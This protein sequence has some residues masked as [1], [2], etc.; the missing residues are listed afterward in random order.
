MKRRNLF[1]GT[2]HT[3]LI[4]TGYV[5]NN[6]PPKDTYESLAARSGYSV[7][8]AMAKISAIKP[9][10]TSTLGGTFFPW[11]GEGLSKHI[12]DFN[13]QFET[14]TISTSNT[15]AYIDGE[16]INDFSDGRATAEFSIETPSFLVGKTITIQDETSANHVF[17]PQTTD[18]YETGTL[19]VVDAIPNN[20]YGV[21][22]DGT[23]NVLLWYTDTL[24]T[25]DGSTINGTA[26]V[27][28]ILDFGSS[29]GSNGT[30][31]NDVFQFIAPTEIG[32][33][34][35]V[36]YIKLVGSLSGSTASHTCEVVRPTSD[37]STADRVRAAING[38]GDAAYD[39]AKISYGSSFTGG[40][41]GVQGIT[42]VDGTS[43]ELITV[44]SALP[45]SML[46]NGI[47]MKNKVGS[48]V[49][50]GSSYVWFT[51][52]LENAVVIGLS[53]VSTNNGRAGRIRTALGNI[54]SYSNG[55]TLNLT[56]SGATN[57]IILTR[58]DLGLGASYHDDIVDADMTFTN[59]SSGHEY[60]YSTDANIL[61]RN[62]ASAINRN[63]KFRSHSYKNNVIITMEASG[64]GGNDKT[65]TTNAVGGLTLSNSGKFSGGATADT[66]TFRELEG[67]DAGDLNGNSYSIL[68]VNSPGKF[69]KFAF[70]S[71]SKT[72]TLN[73]GYIYKGS[74]ATRILEGS[75]L[76][77]FNMVKLLNEKVDR[78]ID[79]NDVSLSDDGTIE[80][81][82]IKSTGAGDGK[83]LTANGSNGATWAPASGGG[84]SRWH[85]TMGGYKTNN[86]SSTN[87]YFQTYPNYHSWTSAD[88]SPT[89]I[90]YSYHDSSAFTAPAAAIIT[91]IDVSINCSDSGATDPLKF[92]I[93]KGTK[94][95]S[96]SSISLT[97]VGDSGT[98]TPVM[99]K[100]MTASATFSSGNALNAGD[101]VYVFIKKDSTTGN[102][103]QYFN[104]TISGEYT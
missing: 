91:R 63:S 37:D 55:I 68:E 49:T 86:N 53:G 51:G 79:W 65:V 81:T 71:S 12:D 74:L 78:I 67:T 58:T 13:S 28:D 17:E 39:A 85:V 10:Q 72:I 3:S 94:T 23:T 100:C 102:Q 26:Q 73:R 33:A 76:K 80:G 90:S 82:V 98:I 31:D 69:I 22:N 62:I 93:F 20:S 21:L 64:T 7:R 34:G 5:A 52:G 36:Q 19:T 8:D 50:G 48:I 27:V 38:S 96:S 70:N 89:S 66:I 47:R 95:N 97:E 104:V 101:S 57:E 1:R 40:T 59:F 44:K 4:S 35:I 2:R 42:A 45:D 9:E 32:G 29:G 11:I 77:N 46:G 87:Y 103:D 84:T 14:V 99:F 75:P 60:T 15:C 56:I 83:V 24:T 30:S 18:Q 61:A 25:V 88:S 54:N 6:K 41:T 16:G 92:Y 43:S